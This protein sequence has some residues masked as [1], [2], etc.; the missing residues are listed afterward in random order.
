M[1]LKRWVFSPFNQLTQLVAREFFIVVGMHLFS[2]AG[3]AQAV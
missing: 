3:L 2:G 1:V